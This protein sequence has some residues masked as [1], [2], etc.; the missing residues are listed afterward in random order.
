MYIINLLLIDTC[1][2]MIKILCYKYN[3]DNIENLFEFHNFSNMWI[4]TR[5]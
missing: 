1:T 5:F 4:D 3:G 2:Y